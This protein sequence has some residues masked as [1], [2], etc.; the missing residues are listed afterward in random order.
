M[1][2]LSLTKVIGVE[3]F[4]VLWKYMGKICSAIMTDN[5]IGFLNSFIHLSSSKL[6]T[7]IAL[8]RVHSRVVAQDML[9][10]M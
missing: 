5:F 1:D 7:V 4:C 2:V 3:N 10:S 9:S 6:V 8:A